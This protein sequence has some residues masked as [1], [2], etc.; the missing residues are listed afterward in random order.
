VLDRGVSASARRLPP[1]G[2]LG[3]AL[4]ALAWPANWLL[5]GLRTHVFFFPLWFG[6]VLALDGWIER[7]DGTSPGRRAPRAALAGFALSV[8][9]WWAFEAANARLGNWEYL[10]RERFG[11][12]EFALLA[13]L[14]FSTVVPAVLVAAE[15]ARGLGWLARLGSGPRLALRGPWRLGA[16][17]LGAAL[18]AA[19]LRWPRTCYPLLWPSG[20]FLLEPLLLARG[21]RGLTI[22]LARGDWRPFLA[23]WIGGSACGFFWELWNE[24]SFPKWI[25]HIPPSPVPL[26]NHPKLFEMPLAGYLG[27]GPFALVVYQWKELWLGEPELLSGPARALAR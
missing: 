16:L 6:A 15:W 3:L 22:D 4:A 24:H 20:L 1:R 13:S 11:D 14:S 19:A 7:R 8:P 18:L 26:V 2:W 21:R 9:L 23:L 17:G 25:Y 10:G 27:Y 5:P 12:L